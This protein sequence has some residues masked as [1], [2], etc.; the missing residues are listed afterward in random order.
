MKRV[1]AALAGAALVAVA[2]ILLRGG[3][4]ARAATRDLW[5]TG[6]APSDTLRVPPG[7]R[8]R[9]EVLNGTKTRGLARRAMLYLRDRGFDVVS[10]GNAPR[11]Y[12][13]TMVLDHAQGARWA[14]VAAAAMGG[15]AR[16]ESRPDSSRYLDITVIVGGTWRPPAEP[17][18][19]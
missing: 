7:T 2:S 5:V 1:G 6:A 18:H 19:P 12:D 11:P 10:L 14:G 9:V 3:S 17:F 15:G 4:T 8:V 13:T 16:V